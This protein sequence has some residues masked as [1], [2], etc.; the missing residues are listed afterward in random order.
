MNA[1]AAREGLHA[2]M[3]TPEQRE[4]LTTGLLRTKLVVYA[5][6]AREYPLIELG[7]LAPELAYYWND[8]TPIRSR[9]LFLLELSDEGVAFADSL[10][11]EG[12]RP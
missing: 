3:L 2:K 1:N 11:E 9:A 12:E 7:H 6:H 4:A 5:T 8:P 10:A